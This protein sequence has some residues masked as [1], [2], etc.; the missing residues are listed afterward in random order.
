MVDNNNFHDNFQSY[1]REDD[2]SGSGG[3]GVAEEARG[4]RGSVVEEAGAGQ[5]VTS[6]GPYQTNGARGRES[7]ATVV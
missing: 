5:V 6:L 3:L 7:R 2:E 1:G 4:E